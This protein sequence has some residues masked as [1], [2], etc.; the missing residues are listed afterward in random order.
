[1]ENYTILSFS[2]ATFY[3][4]CPLKICNGHFIDLFLII[5]KTL[6]LNMYNV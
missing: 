2:F 6:L 5:K 3:F 1:M 4:L